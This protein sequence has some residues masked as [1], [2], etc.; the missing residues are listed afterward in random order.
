MIERLR[1]LLPQIV[2]PLRTTVDDGTVLTVTALVI[3]LWLGVRPS[4]APRTNSFG[5]RN[6]YLCSYYDRVDAKSA[7]HEI[8]GRRRHASPRDG[9]Q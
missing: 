7:D 1:L 3:V 4:G 8:P 5:C 6:L 9:S 2:V